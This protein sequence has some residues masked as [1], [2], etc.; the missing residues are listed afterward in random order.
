MPLS[1]ASRAK[2][3]YF[4]L[5]SPLMF[6]AQLINIT[7]SSGSAHNTTGS[8]RQTIYADRRPPAADLKRSK[9]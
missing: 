9:S 4:A 2:A 6:S 8:V 1:I 5:I 7:L 3:L